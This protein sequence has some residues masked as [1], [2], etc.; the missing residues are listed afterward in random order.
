MG[1]PVTN[2]TGPGTPTPMPH[3]VPGQIAGGGAQL[4]EQ[5][6]DARQAALRSVGDVGRLVA[7][8]DDPAVERWSARRRCWSRPG[9][10]RARGRPRRGRSAGAAAGRRCSG[11][12]RPRAP[13][14]GRSGSP[15]RWATTARDRPVR[16][17]TSARD[18]DA[19]QA[20][21]SSR[22]ATSAS[23]VTLQSAVRPSAADYSRYCRSQTHFCT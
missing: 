18:R 17:T 16:A 14:P 7:V 13:G 1:V 5:L 12:G 15:T 3:N 8:G 4:G 19:T 10:R 20:R 6:V 23:S 22:T 2:S 21:S 9:R 11:R